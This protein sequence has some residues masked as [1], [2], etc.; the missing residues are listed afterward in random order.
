MPGVGTIQ[1]L[2]GNRLPLVTAI[3]VSGW[4]PF[5]T[6]NQNFRVRVVNGYHWLPEFQS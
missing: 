1:D 2:V 4:L 5:T 3:L 6:G